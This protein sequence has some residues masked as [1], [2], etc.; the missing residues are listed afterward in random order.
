MKAGE[1][2]KR[3]SV[4]GQALIEGVMMKGPEDIAIAIRKTDGNI[5]VKKD[6]VGKIEKSKLVKI[7]IIRGI[8]ALINSMVIGI[9][10]LTYSAEFFEEDEELE[11]GKI[12][13]W[14]EN[15]FGDKA[16]DIAIYISVV[17]A[18]AMAILIFA[19]IPTFLINLLKNV[20]ESKLVLSGMEGVVK[21]IMFISYIVIISR[22]KDIQRVF[23]YHGA[24]H[25]AIHC[26]ESGKELTVENAKDFTTL[27]PRCGTSFLLIVMTVS[28]LLFS[29]LGWENFVMRI[30]MK[31]LLL[32]L[33]SGISYEIIRWAGRSDA[34]ITKIISHPG[35]MLQKLTTREPNDKQLEVAIEALKNV[36][37][38]DEDGDLW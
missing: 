10:A 31:L 12:D 9:K 6:P 21:I 34:A 24:E 11:K 15:K 19:I 27:H 13:I 32:P 25:K 33:V 2:M 29:L 7:P 26:Y 28:I 37:I 35:L 38:K 36:S 22:M 1:N 30:A 14:L 16:D 20:V 18:L 8:I 23:Q 17:I 3:T 5:I 4:G